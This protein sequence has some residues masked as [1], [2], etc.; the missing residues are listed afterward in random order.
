[1][2]FEAPQVVFFDTRVNY[3]SH[4][5]SSLFLSLSLSAVYDQGIS[6]ILPPLCT[7]RK[8]NVIRFIQRACVR[9]NSKSS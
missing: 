2:R 3:D 6:F 4:S 7:H 1:M 9:E 5:L 8:K